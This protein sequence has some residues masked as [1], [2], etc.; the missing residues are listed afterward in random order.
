M[1]D[2][3]K[4]T[5]TSGYLDFVAEMNA[6]FTDLAVMFG[7]GGPS[8]FP[9]GTLRFNRSG[10]LFDEWDGATFQPK[11]IG[12]A[13]GGT[14]SNNAAG[15]RVNLGIGSMGVQNSNAVNITGGSITGVAY[16]ASDIT[17]G[18]VPLARG[19]T[20][21]SLAI[22]TPGAILM[23]NGAVV[24]FDTGIN[25]AQ[26]NGSSIV[27]GTVPLARLGPVAT[28]PGPNGFSGSNMYYANVQP[29]GPIEF[30]SDAPGFNLTCNTAPA[31]NRRMRVY[32]GQDTNFRIERLDDGY[33]TSVNVFNVT[34]AGIVTCYGGSI[35]NLNGAAISHGQ[36][37]AAR[38]GA[39][40]A[41]SSTFLRGDL[42]W[43][44]V[45]GGGGTVEPIPS[46]LIAIFDT[47]CPAGWTRV[48]A[49]DGRFPMGYPAWGVQGGSTSHSHGIGLNTSDAG[50]HDHGVGLSGSIS[51]TASGNVSGRTNDSGTNAS[52]DAGGSFNTIANNH[53]HDV[54]IPVSLGVS[55]SANVSGRTD[56]VGNHNHQLNGNTG[57]ADHLPSYLTV[58]Y[59]RR[60]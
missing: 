10:N 24:Y 56:G 50:G 42:T 19:G 2:W 15:A 22:A 21:N 1:A 55:G 57:A 53:G 11:F 17:T 59:C 23:S 41:N 52:A 40:V 14:G 38:M 33:T 18:I 51:G 32:Y 43:Q 6:K 26:L 47:N 9:V 4:P 5:T 37:E 16:S 31:G 30:S 20:G 28:G 45:S 58:V 39:G 7:F 46:G 34:W 60:N 29:G 49:L 25:I 35:H 44:P 27:T 13:G 3:N 48:A 12:L 36:I 8:N 54:N